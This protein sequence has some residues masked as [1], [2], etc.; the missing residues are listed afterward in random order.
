MIR[1]LDE[2]ASSNAIAHKRAVQNA[3]IMTGAQ[4]AGEHTTVAIDSG[5]QAIHDSTTATTPEAKTSAVDEQDSE[6]YATVGRRN[7]PALEEQEHD[8]LLSESNHLYV[9]DTVGENPNV[10]E[11]PSPVI[12]NSSRNQSVSPTPSSPDSSEEE[13]VFHGRGNA[14]RIIADPIPSGSSTSESL[15]DAFAPIASEINTGM[16][17]MENYPDPTI[18]SGPDSSIPPTD[19]PITPMTGI[20][21]DAAEPYAEFAEPTSTVTESWDRSNKL[22]PAWAHRSKPGIGWLPQPKKPKPQKSAVGLLTSDEQDAVMRDFYENL[23]E[24]ELAGEIDMV[25]DAQRLTYRDLSQPDDPVPDARETSSDVTPQ[26]NVLT[27]ED[28]PP[29]GHITM[30][31]TVI[32][33]HGTPASSNGNAVLPNGPVQLASET[34]F[35]SSSLSSSSEL[36]SSDEDEVTEDGRVSSTGAVYSFNAKETDEDGG[37]DKQSEASSD[38]NFDFK[39]EREKQGAQDLRMARRMARHE[40]RLHGL[41]QG[42]RFDGAADDESSGEEEDNDD[43]MS[44]GLAITEA[45]VMR[46][47]LEYA[48]MKPK[49]SGRRQHSFPSASGLADALDQDP[50]N[51]FDVMDFDRPSLR[52]KRKGKGK[53]RFDLDLSDKEMEQHLQTTWEKDRQAKKAR[54][55]RREEMRAQGLVGGK[56]KKVQSQ[57]LVETDEVSLADVKEMIHSFLNSTLDTQDL[58]PMAKHKRLAV[59]RIAQV[60]E[61]KS[62]SRNKEPDRHIVL[63]KTNTTKAFDNQKFKRASRKV[64][65]AF[66]SS[67]DSVSGSNTPN[68]H[69]SASGTKAPSKRRFPSGANTPTKRGGQ[70]GFNYRDG[71]IVGA[72]AAEID[73][74]NRGRA[75]LEKMGWSSGMALGAA[76]NK[77]I[78]EPIAQIVKRSRYGL[79]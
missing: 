76:D 71:D 59:H 41:N 5:R 24:Q 49:K 73:A 66:P 69:G 31:R 2:F 62:D 14:V 22:N 20:T 32:S 67:R 21:T 40:R 78:L 37:G 3:S 48:K 7:G 65:W 1:R 42:I 52:R 58:P 28:F 77:G 30:S 34:S 4:A 36:D 56:G 57:T 11:L 26:T 45:S 55:Q 16:A 8:E 29:A 25:A 75:M 61:L 51:G 39:D 72:G 74:E 19:E 27:R 63:T 50:Y 35:V 46:A 60:F 9:T 18:A 38:A 12:N 47:A 53:A 6:I 54:K 79:G 68:K 13:I 43:T 23:L 33:V 10:R 44:D 17:P 15:P 64:M 70:G